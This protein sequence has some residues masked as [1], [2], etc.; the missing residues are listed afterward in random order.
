MN[1]R[2]M[3]AFHG[4]FFLSICW[5]TTPTPGFAN[6][7]SQPELTQPALLEAAS[8]IPGETPEITTVGGPKMEVKEPSYRFPMFRR[9]EVKEIT[10]TFVFKNIG[11]E[12]LL[13]KD[14]KPTCG[15]TKAVASSRSL[16]PGATA[17]LNT[18]LKPKGKGGFQSISVHV[19]TNEASDEKHVFRLMGTVLS[20]W[21]VRPAAINL[22]FLAPGDTKSGTVH[23]IS[24]YAPGDKMY[25]IKELRADRPEI[26][27]VTKEYEYPTEVDEN[28]GYIDVRRPIEISVTGGEE[29]GKQSGTV[30]VVTD[31][32]RSPNHK[33]SVRWAVVG[34]LTF[35]PASVNVQ[36]IDSKTQ[37]VHLGI[38]SRSNTPFEIESFETRNRNG[39][40]CEDLRIE[41]SPDSGESEK[42]FSIS[43][44]FQSDKRYESRMGD[45]RFL[46]N[47]P[48][49]P[50][51]KVPYSAKYRRTKE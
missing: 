5:A 14:I 33:V 13:I 41:P 8:S 44:N 15:C 37:S 23:L 1:H 22:P 28:K 50:E 49:V 47:H 4:F 19:T 38:T 46:T 12:E 32:G 26:R 35:S 51:I 3:R 25:G 7:G 24:M 10:H 31:D 27:A 43:L 30:T 21:R 42:N 18:V 2:F 45:I 20:E 40:V 9:G 11:D 36:E 6:E 48:Q 39:K 16:P 17:T 34:D 29:L